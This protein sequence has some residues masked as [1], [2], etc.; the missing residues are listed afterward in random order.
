MPRPRSS[1][2]KRRKELAR[3]EKRRDKAEKK[4]QR[5]IEKQGQDGDAPADE[6]LD[7]EP[8]DALTEE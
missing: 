4:A 7:G 5:K 8:A 6:T 3:A 2:E 1:S